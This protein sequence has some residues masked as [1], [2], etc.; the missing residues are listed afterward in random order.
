MENQEVTLGR[1]ERQALLR[2]PSGGVLAHLEEDM[3]ADSY[4]RDKTLTAGQEKELGEKELEQ[5]EQEV[6]TCQEARPAQ[7]CCRQ[8][9]FH[10]KPKSIREGF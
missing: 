5:E 8:Q 6:Q 2:T 1:R 3:P 7:V 10:S 9:S 4:R